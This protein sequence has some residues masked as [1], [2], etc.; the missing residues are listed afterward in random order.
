MVNGWLLNIMKNIPKCVIKRK[1]CIWYTHLKKE[2]QHIKFPNC[3]T[4]YFT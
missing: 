2:F 4:Q 1:C 3:S